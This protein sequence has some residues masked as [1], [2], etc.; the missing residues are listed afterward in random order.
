MTTERWR[1]PVRIEAIEPA[2]GVTLLGD[3]LVQDEE[4][5]L[6]DPEDFERLR[7]GYVCPQCFEPFENPFPETCNVC[8]YPV[9][10]R[11]HEFLEQHFLGETWVGPTES[12]DDEISGID[13]RAKKKREARAAELG[14]VLPRPQGSILVPNSLN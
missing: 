10:A 12:Y 8:S 11:A 9:R 1:K 7:L 5:I 14:I 3:R 4:V 2:A 13:E 6:S